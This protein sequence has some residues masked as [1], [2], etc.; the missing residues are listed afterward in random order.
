M[1]ACTNRS[2]RSILSSTESEFASLFVPN[3][4]RP[5]QPCSSSQRQWRTYRSGSGDR[6]ALNGVTAGES[7]P[8]RRAGDSGFMGAPECPVFYACPN[9]PQ[10]RSFGLEKEENQSIPPYRGFAM[11]AVM[12]D[13]VA[14]ERKAFYAKIDKGNCAPL[15][16]VLHAL[17]TPT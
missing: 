8:R 15:W 16:E 2:S 11:S 12:Q 4:A 14:A 1:P 5:E 17:V 13:A 7:T 9:Q 10:S 6:S 3:T